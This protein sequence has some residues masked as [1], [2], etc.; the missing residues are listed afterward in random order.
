MYII[1]LIPWLGSVAGCVYFLCFW[2]VRRARSSLVCRRRRRRRRVICVWVFCTDVN[3][4]ISFVVV[5]P[6]RGATHWT[7]LLISAYSAVALP[8]TG[9]NA[10][11]RSCHSARTPC[12]RFPR[13]LVVRTHHILTRAYRHREPRRMQAR[14]GLY[15]MCVH[16][17]F[18]NACCKLYHLHIMLNILCR[19]YTRLGAQV[20]RINR[21][22]WCVCVCVASHCFV[23]PRKFN[24]KKENDGIAI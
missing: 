4:H 11:A 6:I 17:R 24:R 13:T 8:R 14:K 22:V 21:V 12:S 3:A 9:W 7:G 20:H 16:A 19:A 15:Y 10:R 2:S 23:R 5:V 18:A 1:C